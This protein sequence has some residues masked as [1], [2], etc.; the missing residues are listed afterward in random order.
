[1]KRWG[2]EYP[3]GQAAREDS[4]GRKEWESGTQSSD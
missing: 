3:R 2:D 1:M 4:K